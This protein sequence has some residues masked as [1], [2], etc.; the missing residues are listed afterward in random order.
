M[1]TRTIARFVIAALA[2]LGLIVL[3]IVMIVKILSGSGAPT[4]PQVNVG[5]YGSTNA[6][7][8]LLIDGITNVDQSHYQLRVT[9]SGTLNQIDTIQGYEGRVI[10][11]QTYANNSAGYTQFLQSLQ[12]LGFSKGVK[13]AIDYRGYCPTGQRYLYQFNNG[14]TD[15]FSFW[16]TSCGQGTFR[17]SASQVR[18][19]FERQI[20]T[21]D[22]NKFL[23]GTG[24]SF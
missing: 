2:G 22:L 10:R 12:L 11:T 6:T 1:D 21:N 4:L 18:Q 3:T 13:S 24:I 8:T 5:R 16:S 23:T 9:V 19:L 15:L 14:S 20:P 17:G 7:S